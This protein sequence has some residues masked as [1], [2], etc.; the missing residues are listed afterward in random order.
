MKLLCLERYNLQKSLESI[1]ESVENYII[2][3]PKDKT[4]DEYDKF[5]KIDIGSSKVELLDERVAIFKNVKISK[6]AF[7]MLA[8][9]NFE[10]LI[11]VFTG[12][13]SSPSNLLKTDFMQER[14]DSIK[15]ERHI[16]KGKLI[17][18]N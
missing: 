14:I 15:E 16:L 8:D 9:K 10:V 5:G 3:T 12:R 2:I 18:E 7:D 4:S 1:R 6:K 11:N 17:N 13:R